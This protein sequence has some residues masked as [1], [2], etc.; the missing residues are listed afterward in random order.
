MIDLLIEY[1]NLC[2]ENGIEPDP[3]EF[4]AWSMLGV[5]PDWFLAITAVEL[6]RIG[7]EY[8]RSNNKGPFAPF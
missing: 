3:V 4:M 8:P 2:R 7:S 6:D 5:E 1:N